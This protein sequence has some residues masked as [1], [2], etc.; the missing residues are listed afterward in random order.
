MSMVHHVMVLGQYPMFNQQRLQLKMLKAN[1]KK[2]VLCL[3][4]VI[5]MY[6]VRLL[7]LILHQNS[8]LT[9]QNMCRKLMFKMVIPPKFI[10]VV[11]TRTK[12]WKSLAPSI[13]YA[14]KHALTMTKNEHSWIS[15][16]Q[17]LLSSFGL[18]K[19]KISRLLK[20]ND[21]MFRIICSKI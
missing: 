1:L 2:T 17:I 9:W 11:L 12:T 6:L 10:K 15:I 18:C 8:Q 16:A 4:L 21:T 20:Q 19:S 14:S 5:R 7:M 3:V 13:N